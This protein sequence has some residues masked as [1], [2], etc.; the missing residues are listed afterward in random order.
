[1]WNV[2]K[3]KLQGNSPG[4]KDMTKRAHPLSN[5]ICAEVSSWW[6]TSFKNTKNKHATRSQ[7]KKFTFNRKTIRMTLYS[8]QQHWNPKYKEEMTSRFWLNVILGV[9][10][11]CTWDIYVVLWGSAQ[12]WKWRHWPSIHLWP[13]SDHRVVGIC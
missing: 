11:Y 4:M 10:I 2:I 7:K 12:T 9:G 6:D 1:M 3:E 5:P 8:K 13:V